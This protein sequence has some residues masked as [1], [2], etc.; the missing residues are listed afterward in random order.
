MRMLL[1]LSVYVV[2][3]EMQEWRF[4]SSREGEKEERRGSRVPER[5]L[6]Q[7]RRL[8][9]TKEKVNGEGGGIQL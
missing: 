8:Y 5:G 2:R 3:K 1:K 6:S 4:G 9:V 7:M